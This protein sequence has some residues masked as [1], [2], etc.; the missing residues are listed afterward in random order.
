[1]VVVPAGTAILGAADSDL[2]R[3]P[4]ETAA[5]TFE[6]RAPF[7]VSR[8]EVT[9]DQYEVFVH[10]TRRAIEG[11]CLTDRSKRG[12]WVFDA[13]TTFRDPGFPQRSDHSVACVS[14]DD[15]QAYVVWLNSQTDG[16]YRLLTEIEWEYV[17]RASALQDAHTW[18]PSHDQ[19]GT[20]RPLGTSSADR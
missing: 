1:M 13:G 17:S 5:R 18:S 11:N 9:R 7:V 15:A 20:R 6:I 8:Y 16:G 2:F 4:D 10:A 14:W 19:R 12:N 3:N